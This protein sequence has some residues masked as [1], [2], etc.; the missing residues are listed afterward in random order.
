[1]QEAIE[2]MKNRGIR[3]SE[4]VV[5]FALAQAGESNGSDNTF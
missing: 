2:R 5:N 1:M 4:K 3:L